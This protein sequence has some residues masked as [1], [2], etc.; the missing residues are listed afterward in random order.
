MGRDP[1]VVIEDLSVLVCDRNLKPVGHEGIVRVAKRDGVDEAVGGL[2]ANRLAFPLGLAQNKGL[3]RS[4]AGKVLDPFCGCGM[5]RGLAGQE[6]VESGSEDLFA[7]GLIG[8]EIVSEEGDPPGG[9]VGSP[10]L[11]PSDRGG[12]FAILF[13][14]AVL[15]CDKLR[16]QPHDAGL[17]GGD[18]GGGHGDVAMEDR[19]VLMVA[20]M[21]GR[22]ENLADRGEG[23]GIV[24]SHKKGA[25]QNPVLLQA[26]LFQ[27]TISDRTN[28]RG[29]FVRIDWIEDVPD[30]NI[31]GDVVGAK[32]RLDV[33]ASRKRRHLPLIRQKRRRLGIENRKGRASGIMHGVLQIVPLFPGVLELAQVNADLIQ[34]NLGLARR[35]VRRMWGNQKVVH[36]GKTTGKRL[37][38]PVYRWIFQILNCWR[39][40]TT[41]KK[42]PKSVLPADNS[43]QIFDQI[44]WRVLID[45]CAKFVLDCGQK[46][47]PYGMYRY[48][49]RLENGLK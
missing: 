22:T 28:D 2:M 29:D 6:K 42:D 1:G 26:F 23:V 8:V 17:S 16:R 41:Q 36:G 3:D 7:E 32:E 45:D 35:S 37:A 24:E 48:S 47:D 43:Q 39:S 31:R 33:V 44:T 21:A 34:K 12:P 10:L 9:I 14:M 25:V 27:Q 38:C 20:G 49:A 46:R 11:D 15:G 19:P 18:Q 30:L 13:F 5:G 4:L 40:C